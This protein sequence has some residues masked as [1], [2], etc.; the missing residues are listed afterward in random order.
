[1]LRLH[2]EATVFS[3]LAAEAMI[4]RSGIAL[5]GPHGGVDPGRSRVA[6]VTGGYF[7]ALGVGAGLGRALDPADDRVLL[8]HPLAVV[9]AAYWTR[10]LGRDP[11]VLH[12]GL[13]LNGTRFQIVGVMAPGFSGDWVGRPVDVWVPFSMHQRVFIELPGPMTDANTHAFHLIGRLAPG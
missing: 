8:G 11:D 2:A 10:R 13:T 7:A 9:S 12:R 1:F 5:D 6:V 4:D 3:G